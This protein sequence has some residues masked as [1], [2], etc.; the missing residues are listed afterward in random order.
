MLLNLL[1]NMSDYDLDI[2]VAEVRPTPSILAMA[3]GQGLKSPKVVT[4]NEDVNDRGTFGAAVISCSRYVM[5][6]G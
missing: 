6:L 2:E 1:L 4:W 5:T 3:F